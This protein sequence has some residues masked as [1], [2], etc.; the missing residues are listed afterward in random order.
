MTAPCLFLSPRNPFATFN[1]QATPFTPFAPEPSILQPSA[2][3][4]GLLGQAVS[5][6]VTGNAAMAPSFSSGTT[7]QPL[8]TSIFG[9][10]GPFNDRFGPQ[11]TASA[12]SSSIFKITPDQLS[13]RS[14]GLPSFPVNAPSSSAPATR[15]P[16]FNNTWP[17]MVVNGMVNNGELRIHFCSVFFYC[18]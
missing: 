1:P 11:T 13:G 14:F 5:A 8:S 7:S 17:P 6:S 15:S 9:S 10:N 16:L 3:P 18:S 12:P 2:P 4:S